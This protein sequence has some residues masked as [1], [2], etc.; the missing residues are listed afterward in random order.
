MTDRVSIANLPEAT[1]VGVNDL[2]A[3]TQADGVTRKIN[4]GQAGSIGSSST[5][6]TALTDTPGAYG[7][8]AGKKVVVRGSSTGLEFQDDNAEE[9]DYDNAAS[10]LTAVDVQAAIDEIVASVAGGIL[11]ADNGL[12]E[13]P[14]QNVQLGGALIQNTVVGAAA[15]GFNLSLLADGIIIGADALLDLDGDVVDI[16]AATNVNIDGQTNVN[17]DAGVEITIQSQGNVKIDADAGN[18]VINASGSILN[19]AGAIVSLDAGTDINVSAQA[20]VDIDADLE[21]TLDAVVNIEITALQNLDLEGQARVRMVLPS[22]PP[23]IGESLQAINVNGDLEWGTGGGIVTADNGLT[24]A[25]G[26]VQLGGA[27]LANT[28]IGASLSGFTFGVEADDILLAADFGIVMQA[29]GAG[30][31]DFRI[32]TPS[33]PPVAGALWTAKDTLGNGQWATR[34]Q[35]ASWFLPFDAIADA[36]FP[37]IGEVSNVITGTGADFATTTAMRHTHCSILVNAITTGGDLV[38]SGDSIDPID[39]VV[40]I[41]DT[42]I[43]VLDTTAAQRYQTDKHWLEITGVDVSSGTITGINYDIDRL[44]YLFDSIEGLFTVVRVLGYRIQFQTNNNGADLGMQMFVVNDDGGKKTS[45]D[46]LEDI[47]WT[48]TNG[49]GVITD[50]LRGGGSSRAYNANV[51]Q[52]ASGDVFAYTMIDFNSF[53]SGGENVING[54]L[55]D[56]LQIIFTGTGGGLNNIEHGTLTIAFTVEPS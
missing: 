19:T 4:L 7:G 47:I 48:S 44:S 25:A 49:N 42:E 52:V 18:T 23:S 36:E 12:T 11:T 17:L 56:G 3:S 2:L 13:A 43:I 22:S 24:A 21:I 55:N 53:F 29:G 20:N 26:N 46:T 31:G 35:F 33:A 40:T 27:L 16:D 8:Q 37:L 14:S 45:V 28:F 32:N 30:S 9:V 39:G 1:S 5:S 15:S 6:F 10:G 50:N 51:T 34:T 41:A 38:V 54:G